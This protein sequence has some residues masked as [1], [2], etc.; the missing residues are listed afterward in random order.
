MRADRYEA[1]ARE[2]VIDLNGKRAAIAAGYAEASAEVTA[3][4]LLRK[5]KCR[6]I[7]NQLLSKRAS[8]LEVKAEKVVEELARLAFSNLH[9]Y[10]R[11]N[12]DGQADVDLSALT[13]DQAAAI[14]EITVDTTGGTGDGERRLV[15]RTKIKLVDKTKNLELLCRHLGMLNDRLQ[16][17]GLENLAERI[18]KLR[19]QSDGDVSAAA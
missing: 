8:K 14:S 10:I 16:V 9:D 19:K 4:Q 11:V 6:A 12:D 17:T 7:I 3:S 5:T 15:L 13:R 2:Y 18:N 1:F